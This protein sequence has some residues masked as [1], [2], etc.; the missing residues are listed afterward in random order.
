MDVNR[1][2]TAISRVEFSRPVKLALQDRIITSGVAVLDYGCGRGDDVLR[3]S[4]ISRRF[5]ARTVAQRRALTRCSSHLL[6][7][8]AW[9]DNSTIGVRCCGKH[10]KFL[11][12]E[13]QK[14]PDYLYTKQ[15]DG[16]WLLGEEEN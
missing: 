14:Q 1:S 8:E 6:V 11:Q 2:R 15:T 13:L 7:V 3:C 16:R 5:S 10:F 4:G 12:T 9:G